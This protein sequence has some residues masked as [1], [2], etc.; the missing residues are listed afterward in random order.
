MSEHLTFAFLGFAIWFKMKSIAEKTGQPVEQFA[1]SF[2]R[3]TIS[4]AVLILK[5]R[6]L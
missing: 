2:R 3:K 6:L 1:S 4:L 5:N